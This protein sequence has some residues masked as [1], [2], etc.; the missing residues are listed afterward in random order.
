MEFIFIELKN[1][2]GNSKLMLYICTNYKRQTMYLV[3]MIV[4]RI[5]RANEKYAPGFLL[6]I[7]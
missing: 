2:F 3:N 6:S 4:D 7:M 1:K 5:G